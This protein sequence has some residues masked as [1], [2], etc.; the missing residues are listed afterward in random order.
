MMTSISIASHADLYIHMPRGPSIG[1]EHQGF[2]CTRSSI[3]HNTLFMVV[4]LFELAFLAV[5]PTV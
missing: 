4:L 3:Y 1:A 2:E 5:D